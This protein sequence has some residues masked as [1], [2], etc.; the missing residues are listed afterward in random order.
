[1]GKRSARFVFQILDQLDVNLSGLTYQPSLSSY[2]SSI[3]ESIGIGT[4]LGGFEP[5]T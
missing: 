1:M 5:P 3:A 4:G 2:F